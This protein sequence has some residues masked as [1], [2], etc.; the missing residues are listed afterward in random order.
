MFTGGAGN[1]TFNLTAMANSNALDSIDGGDGTDTLAIAVTGDVTALKGTIKSIE[2]VTATASSGSVGTVETLAAVAQAQVTS[3]A[4]AVSTTNTASA[5]TLT[6]TIGDSVNAITVPNNSTASEIAALVRTKIESVL[7]ASLGA[8]PVYAGGTGATVTVTAPVAG[9]ALPTISMS[10]TLSTVTYPAT[11]TQANVVASDYIAK[12][13]FAVPKTATTATLTADK[14]I[15]ASAAATTDVTATAT[16]KATVTGGKNVTVTGS[17]GTISDYAAGTVTLTEKK[18]GNV[19]VLGGTTV[20]IT[21]GGTALSATSGE[22]SGSAYGGNIVVGTTPSYAADPAVV[23]GYP[24][25]D[26]SVADQP[27]G[28]VTIKNYTNWTSQLG[29]AS[30]TYGSGTADVVTNGSQSVSVATAGAITVTDAQTTARAVSS[31]STV[32]GTSTLS[33]VTVEGVNTTAQVT[34]DALTSL[35]VINTGASAAVTVTN[36][37]AGGHALALTLGNNT[38]GT[39]VTD[40]TAT[41]VTVTTESQSISTAAN[42][43]AANVDLN[44]AAATSLT[45]NNSNKVTLTGASTLDGSTKVTA[46]TLTGSATTALG[47]ISGATKLKTI[48]ASGATG[49]VTVT[50]PA[51]TSV[52]MTLTGGAGK[53]V[54]TL[55]GSTAP[56]VNSSGATVTTTINLGAGNDSVIKGT[57]GAIAAGSSVNGGDGTDTIAASLLNAGNASVITGFEV[58]GLDLT[59]GS[60]DTNLLVG[61]TGLE[62]LAQGATAYTNVEQAQG[63]AVNSSIGTGATTLTFTATD[64][65]GTADNFTVTFGAKGASDS[66]AAAPTA[67]NAGTIVVQG[68]ENVNIASNQTSGYANNT[69][70]LTSANL[71]T[72]SI[73]G[74]ATKTT[75]AF[76]G[77]NGTNSDTAGVGG[78]VSL[79][80]GTAAS[81]A[82]S[83]N[84]TNV[85]ANNSSAG[86]TINT[87]AGADSITLVGQKATVNTGAG[88]DTITVAATFG[89]KL[90]GGDG[91]DTF[92]VDAAVA[93]A[94][95]EAGAALTTI[96]DL[97]AKDKVKLLADA[98]S[99]TATKV[100]LTSSTLVDA[101]GE[102]TTVANSVKW[103]QYGGDTYIVSNDGATGFGIGDLVVKVTGLVTLTNSTLD[104]TT[105]Y[106]TIV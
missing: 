91:A 79:I 1:D 66:T 68:I 63:L 41:S 87:G 78:A 61:A 73:T 77:T 88:N 104:T 51:T 25:I 81:G 16:T 38:S 85:V 97:A 55:D 29:Q 43:S 20:S 31:T 69:I 21:K 39:S 28:N 37:T 24:Y 92:N 10:S 34:S 50:L 80:D 44:A 32:P 35:K 52:G 33:S 62:L 99:F 102:A 93:T 67:I 56:T 71:K 98:A 27:T 30:R 40:A 26:A 54:V 72:V 58:I 89:G 86:L 17:G 53:D 15:N 94:A 105:D 84:T 90:T 70:S 64:V 6:L 48:D 8:T 3:Y 100:T 82:V 2:T 103:F 14:Q 95:T 5:S 45:F 47:A 4:F 7:D 49:A 18:A 57:S 12:S 60:Y 46:I 23:G 106:L 11:A 9:T 96:T 74:N 42:A 76:V 22:P 83:V 65:V 19:E 36:A 13:T 101:F 75:L 59:S